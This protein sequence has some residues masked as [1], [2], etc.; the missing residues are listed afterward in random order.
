MPFIDPQDQTENE[1]LKVKIRPEVIRLV[2]EYAQF[3]NNSK[4]WYVVQEVLRKSIES[5]KAFQ[6]WR[7]EQVAATPIAEGKKSKVA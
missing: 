1:E 6:K 3:L 5:D 7:K 2:D 4:P